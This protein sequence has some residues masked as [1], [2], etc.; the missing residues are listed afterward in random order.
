MRAEFVGNIKVSPNRQRREFEPEALMGLTESIRTKGL[1]HPIVVRREG[2]ETWLVAGER[3]LKAITDLWALGGVLRHDAQ[4]FLEGQVPVVTLGELSSVE[5]E[6]AE[7]EENVVR[8]D[9]TWQERAA[10]EARLHKFRAMAAASKGADHTVAATTRE[11]HGQ[12][13]PGLVAATR[14]NIVVAGQLSDPEVAGARSLADAYKVVKRKEEQKV[15]ARLGAEVGK[16]FSV[17]SHRL[18]KFLPI[19]ETVSSSMGAD[20]FND[21][22]GSVPGGVVAGNIHSYEDSKENFE[23]LMTAL[24]PQLFRVAKT[25]AHLYLFCDIDRFHWLRAL[26]AKAGWQ[27]HR[28]PLVWHKLQAQ[29]VPWP[30]HGPRRCFE[31]IL[32]AIKGKKRVTRIAPDVLPIGQD[33]NLGLAAQKPV[34]LFQE[35]LSRSTKPGDTVLDFCCG[36]GPIFPAAHAL[37]VAATGIELSQG[38]YGIALKRLKGMMP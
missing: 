7:L 35:L 8:M 32:Y 34:A 16:T 29:R 5:S 38:T 31:V 9:L 22:G 36:T 13:T 27:V 17:A 10:A 2:N 37:T 30:E 33:E 1:L 26:A 14:Q 4:A 11:V 15:N 3:R 28:T 20:E 19:N 6:E 24:M 12:T 25:Q 18:L 23:A 21:A